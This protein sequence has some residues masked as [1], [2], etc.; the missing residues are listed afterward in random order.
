M[1]T[2]IVYKVFHKKQPLL[3][4]AIIH[5]IMGQLCKICS[6]CS[7]ENADSTDVKLYGIYNKYSLQ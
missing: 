7:P 1:T 5:I 6:K 2:T 3:F 4:V